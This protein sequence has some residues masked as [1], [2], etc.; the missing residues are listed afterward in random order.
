MKKILVS[1]ISFI[2]LALFPYFVWAQVWEGDYTI[3]N[4]ADIAALSGYT[5]VTGHLIIGSFDGSDPPTTF[6]NLDGLENLTTVGYSLVIQKIHFL[7][8]I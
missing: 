5:E 8:L 4:E 6:E 7:F 3:R 1:A 2:I